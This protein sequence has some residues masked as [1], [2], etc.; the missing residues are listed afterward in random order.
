MKPTLPL[1]ALGALVS[2]DLLKILD[3]WYP[4][5]SPSGSDLLQPTV[6]AF[7]GGQRALVRALHVALEAYEASLKAPPSTPNEAADLLDEDGLPP[8]RRE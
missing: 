5:R 4:E 6:V 1:S 2:P 3:A 7:N 8:L